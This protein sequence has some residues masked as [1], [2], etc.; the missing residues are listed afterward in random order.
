MQTRSTPKNADSRNALMIVAIVSLLVAGL[1]TFEQLTG[2][3]ASIRGT[4]VYNVLPMPSSGK[5]D[6]ETEESRIPKISDLTKERVCD[7]MVRNFASDS[8]VWQRVSKRVFERLGFRC[9]R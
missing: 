5:V 9:S 8:V 1:V 3:P 2:L 6:T 4:A 7:R